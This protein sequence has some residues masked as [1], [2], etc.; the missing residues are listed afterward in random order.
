M[1]QLKNL[2]ELYLNG[3]TDSIVPLLRCVASDC[4]N[5]QFLKCQCITENRKDFPL[6][7]IKFL[8]DNLLELKKIKF[9][10]AY[11]ITQTTR[12]I[13]VKS[14]LEE[15]LG[16]CKNEFRVVISEDDDIIEIT[17]KM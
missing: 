8:Y 17:R 7:I 14:Q 1:S 12:P 10:W 6:N 13:F 9:V 11:N 3:I 15:N 16:N 2:K 4:P 5:L